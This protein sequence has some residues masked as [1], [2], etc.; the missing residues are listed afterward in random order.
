[1][2]ARMLDAEAKMKS[3]K[4]KISRIQDLEQQL[5]SQAG[6]LQS[7]RR[8][9]G[10][11]QRLGQEVAQLQDAVDEA[12]ERASMVQQCAE[13][14]QSFATAW[15][16]TRQ[17]L[18]D[19]TQADFAAFSDFLTQASASVQRAGSRVVEHTAAR[20]AKECSEAEQARAAAEAEVERLR[21]QARRA[22]AL[23]Q[24]VDEFQRKADATSVRQ[25]VSV[26]LLPALQ[27]AYWQRVTCPAPHTRTGNHRG[28][29]ETPCRR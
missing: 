17:A 2:E 26:R 20:I 25:E 16:P 6:Q 7:L 24:R 12:H 13:T 29:A 14:V 21:P 28:A 27:A 11:A 15:A 3:W 23:A 5:E 8:E 10:E 22:D 18:R 1:M 4:D 9:A 19:S